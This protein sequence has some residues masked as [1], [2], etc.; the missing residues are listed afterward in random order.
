MQWKCKTKEDPLEISKI[1]VG[2]SWFPLHKMHGGCIYQHFGSRDMWNGENGWRKMDDFLPWGW[3]FFLDLEWFLERSRRIEKR[4]SSERV[5]F[6]RMRENESVMWYL[7]KKNKCGC[8]W[9]WT[10][11]TRSGRESESGGECVGEK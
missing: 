8:V 5:R 10:S 1:L 6:E 11:K 7:N 2:H 9:I 4:V 3:E